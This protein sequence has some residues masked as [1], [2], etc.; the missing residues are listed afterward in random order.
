MH[1]D[2]WK[3][4]RAAEKPEDWKIMTKVEHTKRTAEYVAL[5]KAENPRGMRKNVVNES[6]LPSIARPAVLPMAYTTKAAPEKTVQVSSRKPNE[7]PM[8]ITAAAEEPPVKHKRKRRK[9]KKAGKPAG[10]DDD[11]GDDA[12]GAY[13]EPSAKRRG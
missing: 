8:E 2:V 7:V 13:D 1:D 10:G 9:P 5:L 11:D 4:W 3:K 12:E 6:E